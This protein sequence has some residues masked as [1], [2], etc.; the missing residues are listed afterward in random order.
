MRDE[1]LRRALSSPRATRQS[2]SCPGPRRTLAVGTSRRRSR[3]PH[4]P[5]A[6][7]LYPVSPAPTHDD[8]RTRGHPIVLERRHV[9][10]ASVLDQGEAHHRELGD[11]HANVPLELDLTGS[12]AHE[13]SSTHEERLASAFALT[14]SDEPQRAR[15]DARLA[16]RMVR[17]I[18]QEGGDQLGGAFIELSAKE[19]CAVWVAGEMRDDRL[20]CLKVSAGSTAKG[21]APFSTSTT[22]SSNIRIAIDTASSSE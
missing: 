7:T 20:A 2:P 11:V 16:D 8:K 18:L 14:Q 22:A 1:P 12:F 9:P 19:E 3:P 13:S 17:E 21:D 10:L 6:R 5:I 4:L 15:Y